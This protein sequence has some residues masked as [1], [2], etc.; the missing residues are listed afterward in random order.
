MPLVTHATT[1]PAT[2]RCPSCSFEREDFASVAMH[3][4]RT[5]MPDERA[6]AARLKRKIRALQLRLIEGRK[7]R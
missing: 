5:H 4:L 3:Y 1:V 2:H 7:A 6:R